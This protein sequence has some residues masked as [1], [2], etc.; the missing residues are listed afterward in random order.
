MMRVSSKRTGP[1]HSGQ[2]M[3]R[4]SSSSI[5]RPPPFAAGRVSPGELGAEKFEG[6]LQ[7]FVDIDAGLPLEQG[8]RSSDIGLPHLRIVLGQGAEDDLAARGGQ[9]DDA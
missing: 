3:M 7:T 1:L 5:T 8:P 2:A 4:F 9:R 6:Q